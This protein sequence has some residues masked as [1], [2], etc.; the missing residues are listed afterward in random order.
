MRSAARKLLWATNESY[1]F[2]GGCSR[3]V[4]AVLA[5]APATLPKPH[6]SGA[7]ATTTRP[8]TSCADE[9]AMGRR[10]PS[11]KRTGSKWKNPIFIS[12]P[13]PPCPA[14]PKRCRV[15]SACCPSVARPGARAPPTHQASEASQQQGEHE[16]PPE[17]NRPA[18]RA[19]AA[20]HYDNPMPRLRR[21]WRGHGLLPRGALHA[22]FITSGQ[23]AG[24][25]VSLPALSG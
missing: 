12:S 8:E 13:R 19:G 11:Q 15:L 24:V 2:V 7:A 22:L 10:A 14:L 6:K 1:Q 5:A 4:N 9:L 3:A 17:R 16:P 23:G 25:V 21:C 20:R 18:Q